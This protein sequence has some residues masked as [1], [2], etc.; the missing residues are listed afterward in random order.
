MN[1]AKL[2]EANTLTAL[3]DLK[4][5]LADSA[6]ADA[7]R[8]AQ[9]EDD[10]AAAERSEAELKVELSLS[11]RVLAPVPGQVI[12]VK[13]DLGAVVNAGQA[14]VSIETGQPGLELL[15][16]IPPQSARDVRPGMAVRISPSGTRREEHGELL[17]TV[18]DIS[19]FPVSATGLRS[20]LKNDTMATT[21]SR[22]GAPYVARVALTKRPDSPDGYAWTTQR[23]ET[24]SLSSGGLA[25]IEV[26]ASTHRPIELVVPNLQK[27]LGM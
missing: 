10:L 14:I 3:A 5:K 18:L 1:A 4:A 2:D 15:A 19:G 21:L 24:V 27:L 25:T 7:D 12:E 11:S 6:R 9:A 23:G 13:A 20:L 26:T 8:Q 22:D 16:F 17:G